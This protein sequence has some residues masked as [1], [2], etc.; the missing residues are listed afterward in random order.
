MWSTEQEN[1]S[2]YQKKSRNVIW[3]AKTD[4]WSTKQAVR[5]SS[6]ATLMD[7]QLSPDVR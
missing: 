3:T 2:A 5:K 4:E 6:K 1:I 7:T